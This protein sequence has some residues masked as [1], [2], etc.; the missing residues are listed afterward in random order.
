MTQLDIQINGLN[1]INEL[2]KLIRQGYRIFLFGETHGFLDDLKFQKALIKEIKPEVC[3][4]EMLEEKEISSKNDFKNILSKPD[5]ERFSIISTFG[6]IKPTIRMFKVY[7]NKV[8][9]CDL[10]NM[11]RKDI[12]FLSKKELTPQD[13]KFESSLLIRRETHQA[14]IINKILMNSKGVVFVSVGAYHLRK[15]SKLLSLLKEKSVI[16]YPSLKGNPQFE[17]I[18]KKEK[19]NFTL[20]L[21]EDYLKN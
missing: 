1:S 20:K 4:Y 11:G 3:V 10:K 6:E 12:S 8:I 21:N 9:G 5:S 2:K 18:E 7:C 15:D 17:P 19:I 16:C 14:E 13:E